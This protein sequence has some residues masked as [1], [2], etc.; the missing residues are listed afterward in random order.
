MMLVGRQRIGN[1]SVDSGWRSR[2]VNIRP[3]PRFSA[4]LSASPSVEGLVSVSVPRSGP[5]KECLATQSA[6]RHRSIRSVL[7]VAYF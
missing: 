2:A 1:G 5:L 3:A 7:R 6:L 4:G